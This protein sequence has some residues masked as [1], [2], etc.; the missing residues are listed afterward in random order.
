[1]TAQL[2]AIY[3]VTELATLSGLSRYQVH[4]LLRSN[5]VNA[6]RPGAR[7][8]V[9]VPLD[10]LREALPTVWESILTRRALAR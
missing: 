10:S 9:G 3:S 1:M 6:L 5:R 4:R 2:K 8:K 7:K